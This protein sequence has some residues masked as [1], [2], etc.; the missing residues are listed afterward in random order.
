M[1]IAFCGV[2]GHLWNFYNSKRRRFVLAAIDSFFQLLAFCGV[3]VLVLL[4]HWNAW[5]LVWLDPIVFAIVAYVLGFFS[6]IYDGARA[7]QS[8][9]TTFGPAGHAV[10]SQ[11]HRVEEQR[12]NVLTKQ[13]LAGNVASQYELGV[14]LLEA[15]S[16]AA[17]YWLGRAA[18]NGHSEA[19]RYL[20]EVAPRRVTPPPKIDI[21]SHNVVKV[22]KAGALVLLLGALA[23]LIVW[24]IP[25]GIALPETKGASSAHVNTALPYAG[26]DA[27][28]PA[29]PTA[30]TGAAVAEHAPANISH[31]SSAKAST[32]IEQLKLT[33]AQK[34]EWE[35]IIRDAVDKGN[36]IRGST[37]LTVEQEQ[38]QIK[39]LGEATEKKLK[40]LLTKDQFRLISAEQDDGAPQTLAKLSELPPITKPTS[41]CEFSKLLGTQT[42]GTVL[43]RIEKTWNYRYPDHPLIPIHSTYPEVLIDYNHP[44]SFKDTYLWLGRH[45]QGNQTALIRFSSN[46]VNLISVGPTDIEERFSLSEIMTNSYYIYRVAQQGEVILMKKVSDIYK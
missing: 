4:F 44:I 37:S 28:A 32:L 8:M 3:T 6:P 9:L 14:A 21:D 19:K 41:I 36:A 43:S 10:A 18:E 45:S 24:R 17:L 34:P 7:A 39:D 31:G 5:H 12:L 35:T 13:A 29:E 22:V 20:L 38:A 15:D 46:G 1:V 33:D 26:I 30:L 27:V 40:A 42:D 25:S 2:I 16:R 11:M 23:S